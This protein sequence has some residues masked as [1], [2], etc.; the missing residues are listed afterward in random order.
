[1]ELEY[2]DGKLVIDDFIFDPGLP[3]HAVITIE[4]T[5]YM[6]AL[7]GWRSTPIKVEDLRA[8]ARRVQP[9]WQRPSPWRWALEGL[10]PRK[11]FPPVRVGRAMTP[12]E[13]DA[14]CGRH[15]LSDNKV[16]GPME[17]IVGEIYGSEA[18]RTVKVKKIEHVA[19]GI[20]KEAELMD[21]GVFAACDQPGTLYIRV[22]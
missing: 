22:G 16:S 10:V 4:D 15:N 6:I 21:M 3:M 12:E 11:G 8:Y 9:S 19:H 20:M 7:A 1:M 2:R 18:A 5:P 13:F 14:F 17:Y